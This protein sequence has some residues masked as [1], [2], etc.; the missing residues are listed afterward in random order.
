MTRSGESSS[1]LSSKVNRRNVEKPKSLSNVDNK[2]SNVENKGS[3][4]SNFLGKAKSKVKLF[5][6]SS[7]TE[8]DSS[9]NYQKSKI[10]LN[11]NSVP[12]KAKE[13]VV[14]KVRN[15]VNNKTSNSTM[16]STSKRNG[17]TKMS[18]TTPKKQQVFNL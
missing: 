10:K 16:S 7:P 3:R 5:N 12:E 15:M 11:S 13:G 9:K 8:P 2:G 1:D 4:I 17:V 6:G 18:T 14:T